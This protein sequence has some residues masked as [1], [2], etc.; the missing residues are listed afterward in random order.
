MTKSQPLRQADLDA[1]RRA[2][3]SAWYYPGNRSDD[4]DQRRNAADDI[5]RLLDTLAWRDLQYQIIKKTTT[6]N[7]AQ[8]EVAERE[9]DDARAALEAT[10]EQLIGLAD[11]DK[12][13]VKENSTLREC[14]EQ[15]KRERDVAITSAEATKR[16][17]VEARAALT[18]LAEIDR[19]HMSEIRRLRLVAEACAAYFG[20]DPVH[21]NGLN[22]KWFKQAKVAID[23][24]RAA[25]Y[26]KDLL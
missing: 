15:L 6:N 7:Y 11:D 22:P 23:S 16:E 5:H 24:L 4:V 17:L 12:A 25:G 3:D 26:L 1:I 14:N 18:T 19:N 20:D 8:R 21:F 2:A 9:L 13:L 10:E